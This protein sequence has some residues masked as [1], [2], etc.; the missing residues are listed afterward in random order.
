LYINT[1][2]EGDNLNNK[3]LP[4]LFA[5]SEM[6]LTQPLNSPS[7]FIGTTQKSLLMFVISTVLLLR[8]R[9]AFMNPD[10]RICFGPRIVRTG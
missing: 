1:I 10:S 5:S 3:I 9:V 4:G 7:S 8:R 2:N 6:I